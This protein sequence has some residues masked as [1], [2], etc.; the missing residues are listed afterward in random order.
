MK[1]TWPLFFSMLAFGIAGCE[2]EVDPNAFFPQDYETSFTQLG[3]CRV[4]N[5]H[6]D[7]YYELHVTKSSAD[8]FNAGMPLPEG[9][10]L[11]KTQYKDKDCSD[12]SRWTVMKKRESGFDAA[13]FDWE[14]QNVDGQGEIAETGKIEY[15]GNCHKACPS[16][17]CSTK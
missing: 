9:T 7:P 2:V 16:G 4:S 15:C 5:I 13:N 10:V 14:W 8:A 11:L 17:V 6:S 12:F 1:N 3:G